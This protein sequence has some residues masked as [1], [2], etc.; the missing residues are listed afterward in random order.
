LASFRLEGDVAISW[1]ES[2]KRARP[3][4][5]QWT[6]KEY[7]S[8]HHLALRMSHFQALYGYAPP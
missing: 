8:S 6:W 5:A 2:R 1:F 4:E 7:N 3:V